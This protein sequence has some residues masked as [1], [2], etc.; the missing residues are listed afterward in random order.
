MEFTQQQLHAID[1]GEP[2]PLTV[3]G[4]SCVLVPDSLYQQFREMIEDWHPQTM[5]RNM[6][7]LMADDWSDPAMSVYD[8]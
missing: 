5:R 6:A 2:L 8:E 3:E 1:S 7:K 4:R